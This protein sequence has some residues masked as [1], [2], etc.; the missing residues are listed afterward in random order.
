M[1]KKLLFDSVKKTNR[2]II[3]DAAWKTC[4]IGAEI[5]ATIAESKL[6]KKLK[7]PIMRISL[8]DTPAPA[9]SVLEN[10]YYPDSKDIV[11]TVKK[12]LY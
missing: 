4:G 5:S 8:P 3:V 10:L 7:A 12:L 11:S 6:L 9:S 1:D 2:L